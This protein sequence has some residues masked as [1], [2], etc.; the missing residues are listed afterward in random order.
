MNTT[1]CWIWPITFLPCYQT[2]QLNLS[3]QVTEDLSIFL[4]QRREE[5]LIALQAKKAKPVV[6][7]SPS[8]EASNTEQAEPLKAPSKAKTTTKAKTTSKA[9][10][11]TASED[12]TLPEAS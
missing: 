2:H 8:S 11:S 3:E 4:A 5:V 12:E 9:K 10:S 6:K 7:A 1:K